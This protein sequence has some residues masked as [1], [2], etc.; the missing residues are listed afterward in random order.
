[1]RSCCVVKDENSEV[2]I[3]IIPCEN[4]EE[5]DIISSEIESLK[6][7]SS[8]CI[9][10]YVDNFLFD[11]E[12]WIVMEYCGG[13]S[14]NDIIRI[15]KSQISEECIRAITAFA[16]SG[17]HHIH[18]V[19]FIHRDIKAANILLTNSGKA[20]LADFGVSVQLAN[21]LQKR[22]TITGTPYWIAPEVVQEVSYGA[23][24]DVWSL[25]ITILEMC[26]GRP[27]HFN[28]H[29]M[30]AIFMISLRPAPKLRE[31]GKWSSEMNDFTK[32]CLVKVS[33]DRA[34]SA[35]LLT[36]PWLVATIDE[37]KADVGI[38]C[39]REL[40][41]NHWDTI[42]ASRIV[43]SRSAVISAADASKRM[44]LGNDELRN[45]LR[46]SGRHEA[47]GG[48]ANNPISVS[49]ESVDGDATL[50]SDMYDT[51]RALS[52]KPV[53]ADDDGNGDDGDGDDGD[54]ADMDDYENT[55]VFQKM[56]ACQEYSVDSYDEATVERGF[57][58]LPMGM[59]DSDTM[60]ASRMGTMIDQEGVAL[61]GVV[62]DFYD[63]ETHRNVDPSGL[64]LRHQVLG[65]GS[66]GV[67][68]KA[69]NKTTGVEVAVKI[70]PCEHPGDLGTEIDF[71][72]RLSCPYII[73][74]HQAFIFRKELWIVMEF[75]GGG[76]VSDV[77][78]ITRKPLL[79]SQIQS[80]SASAV[81]GLSYLHSMMGIHRDIKAANILITK[82][83]RVKLADFGVSAQLTQTL[84]QRNTLIGTPFWMA[85][86]VIQENSYDFKADSW[87]L[88]ITILEMAEC[89]PPHY[90][91]HP[92]RAVFLIPIEPPPTFKK[93]DNW[94][95]PCL[96]FLSRCLVKEPKERAS[97][98]ELLSHE[99]L[100]LKLPLI[101]KGAALDELVDL[102][103]KSTLGSGSQF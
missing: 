9:V 38:P 25:G 95:V 75:C 52:V 44:K 81:L 41:K 88:G 1:M 19:L 33:D 77:L 90:D 49:R 89:H 5:V 39:L 58:T 96:T 31:P 80:I 94:S 16:I 15:C 50:N 29:P 100:S 61:N 69:S 56:D 76:S 3:K 37:V 24:A 57:N 98:S 83:G 63:K 22:K 59:R 26:E 11:E 54:D 48:G 70:L 45:K 4:P 12:L 21:T 20:K 18:S 28:V 91:L 60:S 34:S 23:K 82:E 99:W 43:R 17:L 10:A 84:Q 74:F 32:K 86:E 64:Y 47:I 92:M 27:P 67:V 78:R 101:Q 40:I 13:G 46:A 36:H 93:T 62:E 6:K 103:V 7:L 8:P 73:T 72:R 42:I 2:A 68:Y 55:L 65:K 71:L 66:Y 51:F 102:A 53:G 87:S 30:R 79:E 35:E 14:M 97:I 85:P